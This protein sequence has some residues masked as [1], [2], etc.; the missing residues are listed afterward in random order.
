MTIIVPPSLEGRDIGRILRSEGFSGHQIRSLKFRER[1]I[2]LNGTRS[3]ITR[4]VKAGD[5]LELLLKPDE[6]GTISHTAC[7]L[8]EKAVDYEAGAGCAL[9]E[10]G[11]IPAILY[12]DPDL[13]VLEKPEGMAVHPGRGHYGDSLASRL[14]RWY[15]HSGVMDTVRIVGRLDLETSGVLLVAKHRMAAARLALQ[16]SSGR[17]RKTYLG[18]A[19]GVPYP[20]SGIIDSPIG[21]SGETL[22]R[23]QIRQD[24]KRAVTHYEVQEEKGKHALV[25]FWLE[26]GRTHQIRVH[27]ASNGHPL[28]YDPFYG[29]AAEDRMTALHAWKIEFFQPFSG[30]PIQV[31]SQV[32][33]REFKENGYE[34]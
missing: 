20:P 23:M 22:N 10:E 27:M 15:P 9:A 28:L 12:E 14:G 11:R 29:K 32:T 26:T 25:K 16:Q 33:R 8:G 1:G 34:L 7:R 4:T 18:V 21:P 31:T 6:T 30:R 13:L 2:L 3:R 19:E 5:V 17:L 24:G